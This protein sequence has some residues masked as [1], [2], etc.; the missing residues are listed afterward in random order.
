MDR[1][2]I[3]HQLGYD[4]RS[5]Q[6]ITEYHSG[7]G[8]DLLF[9][10]RKGINSLESIELVSGNDIDGSIS[11]A[12]IEVLADKG[13]LKAKVGVPDYYSAR[14]FPK[15]R[16]NIKVVYKIGNTLPDDLSILIE[17]LTSILILDNI[18]GRTGGGAL[19][20]QG[21]GR[22]YGN[23]GR[24]S[25]IRKRINRQAMGILSKYRSSVVGS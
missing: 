2:T 25:N 5:E 24:Y 8:K 12:S 15:G 19:T 7:I 22:D 21:F 14:T 4:I 23:M 9:L 1:K 3:N 18:E 11:V 17:M 13:I 16:N 6:T 20:V 10:N